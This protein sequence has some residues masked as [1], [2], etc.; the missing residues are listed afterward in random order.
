MI[1][2]SRRQLLHLAGLSGANLIL[3]GCATT[4]LEDVIGEVSEPL[5]Q[6]VGSLLLKSQQPVPEF[7]LND[8]Q[9]EALIV[10][11]FRGNPL[12][13]L[14]KYR[15]RNTNVFSFTK[16]RRLTSPIDY[17]NTTHTHVKGDLY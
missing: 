13:N 12:I 3:G 11:S 2:L 15:L 17:C 16:L 10:N 9:P 6:K 1:H 4:I 7:T 8:I 14:D 5:N